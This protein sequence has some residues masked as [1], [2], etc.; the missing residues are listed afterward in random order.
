MPTRFIRESCRSSKNLDRLTDFEERLFWRLLTTADDYGRFQADGELVRAAC[1]PYRQMAIQKIA[2]ALKGLQ[3]H[4]LIILYTVKDREYGQF[5]TFEVH[6]G[7][8]RAK[9]SKYPAPLDTFLHADVN[10]C[11]QMQT[12]V[13]GHPNTDTNTDLNSLQSEEGK[14]SEEGE[15]DQFWKAYPRKVGKAAALKAFKNA[16]NRPRIDDL[17]QAIS[18]QRSS[19]QWTKDNG[20]FIPHPA[21]WLNRGQWADEAVIP[22]RPHD[23]NGFLDGMKA[24]LERGAS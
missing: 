11:T 15:F 4:H 17:L 24:F 8:P 20:Q 23:P 3:Q 5:R 22:T 16:H 12:D 6:Q 14:K 19:P 1:F 10:I 7:K 13:T 18:A 9:N 21:T 2:D